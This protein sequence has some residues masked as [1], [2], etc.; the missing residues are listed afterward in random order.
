MKFAFLQAASVAFQD[1][2]LS[3]DVVHV[4]EYRHSNGAAV[5]FPSTSSYEADYHK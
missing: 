5:P 3:S 4:T 1:V 2:S